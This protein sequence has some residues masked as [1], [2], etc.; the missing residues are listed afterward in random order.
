VV[1]PHDTRRDTRRARRGRH[2]G[3]EDRDNFQRGFDALGRLALDGVVVSACA[4]D[5]ATGRTLFAVD[6][7]VSMPTAGIGTILLLVE[8]AARLAG[9]PQENL[10]LL[11]R[12]AA[13]AVAGSGVWQHLQV[14]SL[15]IADLAAL[16][17][18][19]SDTLATNVL[20]RRVGLDAVRERAE[21]LGLSRTALLDVV[22][23]E[24]G[25]DDAPQLSIGSARE[26][27]WLLATL[28]NGEIVDSTVSSRVIGW[29]SLN[30]DLSMVSSAF[31]LDPL[32]HRR[33]DHGVLL[34]NTTGTDVGVRAETG[35]LRGPRASAAY[36]VTT[37]FDDTSLHYRLAVLEGLRTLGVD[38]LEYVH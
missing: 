15:P 35:V 22:R 11:D 17:G 8:V 31:G 19:T 23:D 27:T 36:A 28:A 6:D 18:A 9:D 25:P 20:L 21:G 24:R 5:L 16:V 30:P 2:K 26:L 1:I 29:L 37:Q 3:S 38:L 34:V 10:R 13:D 33:P 4:V 14:P 32:V 12:T 7:S